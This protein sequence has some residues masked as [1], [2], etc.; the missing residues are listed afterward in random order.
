[1]EGFFEK[2]YNKFMNPVRNSKI[3]D[4]SNEVRI[5]IEFIKEVIINL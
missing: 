5:K 1:M 4:L 2:Y 3:K